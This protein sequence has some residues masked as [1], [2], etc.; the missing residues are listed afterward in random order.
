MLPRRPARPARA[1]HRE[2]ALAVVLL[3][4]SIL[5]GRFQADLPCRLGLLHT[6]LCVGLLPGVQHARRFE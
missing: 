2:A 4:L 3:S 5:P 6:A 1:E